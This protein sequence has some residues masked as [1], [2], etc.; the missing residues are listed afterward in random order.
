MISELLW[1]L[2]AAQMVMGVFD[3]IYH[4]ELTERLA[5]R[6]S[7]RREL[8]LH[9]VRNW[10]YAVLFATLGW[11]EPH[12]GLA[13]A[14]AVIL[15]VEVVI[16]LMDFVEEDLS[17]KLPASERINHTLLALNYGAILVLLAPVL[18]DWAS[19]ETAL[20]P[21][22][23]GVWT[24]LCTL[25]AAGTVA[26]GLRD[27]AAARRSERLVPPPAADLIAP[28][29][30]RSIVLVTGATGFIGRRLIEALVAAGH[31]VVALVRDPAAGQTLPV[32]LTIV[33]DLWQIDAS[34]SIDAVVNLAGEPI[35]A[36]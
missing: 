19:R 11:A 36:T 22:Y 1:A 5:W 20:R 13:I 8:Q 28:A 16:T 29:G 6:S 18:L 35:A 7:Q 12:G 3:T 9:A 33:T 27:F 21:A 26:L 31:H 24:G 23:H 4:H 17:R 15:L 10:L 2:I 34:T 30:G 25:A 32:P 14:A